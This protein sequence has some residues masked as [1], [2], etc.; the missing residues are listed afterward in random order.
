MRDFRTKVSD[1]ISVR[2]DVSSKI[3]R[4]DI[5]LPG[6]TAVESFAAWSIHRC[7]PM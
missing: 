4:G 1:A 2:E 5:V 3:T 7:L 6:K